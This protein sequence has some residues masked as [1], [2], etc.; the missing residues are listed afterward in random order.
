MRLLLD[1]CVWRG[2]AAE[3][4]AAGHD[5]ISCGDWERDPGD[6]EILGIAN[7]QARVLVT[8]DKDFG[9]LAVVLSR[10]HC[11]IIRLAAI[12]ARRQAQ[13]CHEAIDRY[14]AELQQGAIVTVEPG[15]VRIRSATQN[16]Q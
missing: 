12:S 11:G 4:N 15:R 16:P 14:R 5:V 2:A 13:A 6:E 10:P 1:T 7:A 9:E 8:L 3:L